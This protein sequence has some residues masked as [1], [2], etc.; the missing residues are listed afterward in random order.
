MLTLQY[1]SRPTSCYGQANR[2]YGEK[3][4]KKILSDQAQKELENHIF[5]F[6][7]GKK[8]KK[9]KQKTSRCPTSRVYKKSGDFSVEKNFPKFEQCR[10]LHSHWETYMAQILELNS[11]GSPNPH[12][13]HLKVLKADFNFAL[14]VV[15]DSPNK[16][17]IGLRGYVIQD[18]KN[19][20][21][22]V[23][24]KNK[25]K[26]IPK[27]GTVFAFQLNGVIYR[28]CGSYFCHSAHMRSKQKF[29]KNYQFGLPA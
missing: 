27:K 9:G 19:I 25:L 6:D 28:I 11:D 7:G 21:S 14:V 5:A 18:K 13:I 3:F 17:L 12:D 15:E 2:N 24:E 20:F 22:I 8:K 23:T 4:L 29:K 16:T 10:D 1:G 26:H